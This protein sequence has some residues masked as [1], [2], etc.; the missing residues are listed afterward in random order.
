MTPHW[1]RV[2]RRSGANG[3]GAAAGTVRL[4]SHQRRVDAQIAGQ[5][6]IL[7]RLQHGYTV[8]T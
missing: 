6:M 8:R 7:R 4:D 2:G 1:S 3:A 5:R